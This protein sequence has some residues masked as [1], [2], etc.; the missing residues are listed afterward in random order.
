[1]VSENAY[2]LVDRRARSA[3][4]IGLVPFIA[5]PEGRRPADYRHGVYVV[6]SVFYQLDEFLELSREQKETFLCLPFMFLK[7][8]GDT[9]VVRKSNQIDILSIAHLLKTV[10]EVL[11]A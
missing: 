10:E 3:A 1:M 7:P 6:G 2:Q 5:L 9:M 4:P 11:A 8:E